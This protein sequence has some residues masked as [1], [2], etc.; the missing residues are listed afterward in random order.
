MAGEC[1]YTHFGEIWEGI[2]MRAE[3]GLL[4]R[5]IKISGDIEDGK[6]PCLGELNECIAGEGEGILKFKF[7]KL[8]LRKE[9]QMSKI[10]LMQRR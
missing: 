9:R 1:L 2:D 5:N 4:T 3:V 10:F 8:K 6:E 7:T